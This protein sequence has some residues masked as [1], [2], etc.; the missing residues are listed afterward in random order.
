MTLLAQRIEQQFPKANWL[1]SI[2]SVLLVK[3]YC[4]AEPQNVRKGTV[5]ECS[6]TLG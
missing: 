1:S 4:T 3:L 2:C 6:I 5:S